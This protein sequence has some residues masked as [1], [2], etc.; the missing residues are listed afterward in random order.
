MAR[1][2][3]EIMNRELLTV[4]PGT[5]IRE[6]RDLLRSFSVGAVPVVDDASR[7]LGVLSLRDMLEADGVAAER[8]ARPAICVSM[9]TR[10]DHAAHQLAASDMHH[11]IV[12]DGA[13]AAVGMLSTLD[14]LRAV[15][16]VPA[17]HPATF[18]H[19][20]EATQVSWTD[21]LPLD[22]Q[23]CAGV[24][25]VPGFLLIV[26]SEDGKRDVVVWAEP[27]ANVR[28]RVVELVS[29]PSSQSP[30]LAACLSAP[31]VRFRAAAV[32]DELARQ[33][34]AVLFRD[35]LDHVPPPGAN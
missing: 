34:I 33:R 13:G 32:F 26:R 29:S 2:V 22:E 31:G 28:A 12:V 6:V 21:D 27:C 25:E 17:R 15:L 20:D 24:P 35:R 16:G 7:P 3:D 4:R 18:P 1:T 30:P 9:S 19:W 11:L 5:T 14:L 8:M 23:G 10:I